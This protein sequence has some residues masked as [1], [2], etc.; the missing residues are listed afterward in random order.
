MPG[1]RNLR[2]GTSLIILKSSAVVRAPINDL[3]LL[4]E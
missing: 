4:M 1:S 2:D 3:Q